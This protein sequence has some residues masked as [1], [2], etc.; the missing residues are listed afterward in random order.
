MQI[1]GV[2]KGAEKGS[3]SVREYKVPASVNLKAT[4]LIQLINWEKET[5][6]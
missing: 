5:V 3:N 2:R 4:N 6:T 1:R